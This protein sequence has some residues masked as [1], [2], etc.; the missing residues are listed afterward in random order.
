MPNSA[1]GE[2]C[3]LASRGRIARSPGWRRISKRWK[4]HCHNSVCINASAVV[5]CCIAVARRG[6]V[7]W[8][9]RGWLCRWVCGCVDDRVCSWLWVFDVF[10]TF[11]FWTHGAFTTLSRRWS[12]VRTNRVAVTLGFPYFYDSPPSRGASD[13]SPGGQRTTLPARRVGHGTRYAPGTAK[14]CCVGG[15]WRHSETAGGRVELETRSCFLGVL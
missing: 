11:V 10:R 8:C 12:A 1:S 5:L 14:G 15:T 7:G 2:R 9:I 6:W 3:T 13:P 4:S